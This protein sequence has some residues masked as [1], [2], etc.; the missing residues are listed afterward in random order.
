MFKVPP[1]KALDDKKNPYSRRPAV[2]SQL[3]RLWSLSP[4]ERDAELESGVSSD[5][6][7]LPVEALLHFARA[8]WR[9][10][11]HGT[12][13]KLFRI[14]FARVEANVAKTV[15]SSRLAT[16]EAARE[17]IMDRFV[18]L[19]AE[20]C[21]GRHLR[22][23]Y[24]EVNFAHGLACIRAST[25]RSFDRQKKKSIETVSMDG[26][27]PQTG[28]PR[29]SLE[30]EV[31]TAN[32]LLQIRSKITDPAF[33]SDLYLAIDGLPADQR[34]AVLLSLDGMQTA[35]I[36]NQKMTIAQTLKCTDRTVRN[37]HARAAIGL[38]VALKE[39]N[40]DE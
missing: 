33:R 21:D 6:T 11:D 24:F 35:S 12:Y 10:N 1:L 5:H 7:E 16:A 28:E 22:L 23:D 14:L 17:K 2:E 27:D 19:L 20:D 4:L 25:L 8:A 13:E 36:D 31:A 37:L 30:S 3:E 26:E 15:F 18:S 38:R 40:I 9:Q 39:W 29:R 32:F 34:D